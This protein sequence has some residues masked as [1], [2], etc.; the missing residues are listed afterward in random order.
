M[1]LRWPS[2]QHALAIAAYCLF[3]SSS[4]ASAIAVYLH[5]PVQYI[6]VATCSTTA[7]GFRLLGL[8]L[9]FLLEDV[10]GFIAIEYQPSLDW[11]EGIYT[12]MWGWD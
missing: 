10:S 4:T 7:P 11:N 12:L 9:S 1:P 3:Q 2:H 8:S 5:Q 6:C